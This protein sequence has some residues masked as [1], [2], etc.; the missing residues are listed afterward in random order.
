M[1][2]FRW[3]LLLAA[4]ALGSRLAAQPPLTTVQ[5]VLYT[6]DG[7]RFN[8]VVTVTW[9]TFEASNTSNVSAS[10][11]Q[12]RVSNG[13]LFVQLAPTTNANPPAWYSVQY[14]GEHR[15]QFSETWVVGP[16]ATPLRVR[17]VR[18]PP[19]AV[20]S[21]GAPAAI[22][23]QI[24]DVVGLQAALNLKPSMGAG[25]AVA[26]AAVIDATGAMGGAIGSLTDCVHV[27]GTSG[28]CG[29]SGSGGTGFV[30]G[31][32]PGGTMDGV[33]ATFTL[34]NAPNPASSL[35]IF[36]NGILLRQTGDFNVTGNS[37]VFVAGAIPQAADAL[38]ASYRI[39]VALPGVGF[40]D[41]ETPAGAVNNVNTAFT[42]AQTPA[43]TGSVALYRNGVRV[44]TG[45]DYTITG[46]A[47]TFLAG[48]IP[49]TGDLL[50]CSYRI[51]Q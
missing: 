43:P 42:L 35:A 34:A 17:D 3:R 41:G 23:V 1:F 12:V 25:F 20:T 10:V 22:V 44:R 18:L 15:A 29:G 30:D 36:R 13:N 4:L 7:N 21:Q 45:L 28:S 6:A 37:V 51:A 33:N 5:D 8:G 16:S 26:R 2:S 40:V 24:S 49:Q 14:N 9:K 11:T 50:Q 47:I 27:D 19:G 38:L 39:A 31:E 48:S 32:I 46:N